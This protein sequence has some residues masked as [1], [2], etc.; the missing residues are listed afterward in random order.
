MDLSPQLQREVQTVFY[1]FFAEEMV[2]Q[3]FHKYQ[4]VA[5]ALTDP[6][7]VSTQT[8]ESAIIAARSPEQPYFKTPFGLTSR[9]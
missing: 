7:R 5:D 1:R 6:K 9:S 4:S 3:G 2:K 8:L